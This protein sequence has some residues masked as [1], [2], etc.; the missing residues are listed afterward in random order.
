MKRIK[1]ISILVIA[2]FLVGF[3][4]VLARELGTV[5][6]TNGTSPPPIELPTTDNQQVPDRDTQSDIEVIPPPTTPLVQLGGGIV[7]Q[8]I[9]VNHGDAILVVGETGK[10]MLIDT[11]EAENRNMLKA[12]L[13]EAGV[14]RID[15]LQLTHPHSDHIGSAAW[16][17]RNYPV[18]EVHMINKEH[19]TSIYEGLLDALE[20]V[21]APVKMIE[22][23]YAFDFDGTKCEYIGPLRTNY[24]GLNNC[25]AIMRMEYGEKKLLF[26]GDLEFDGEDDLLSKYGDALDADFFKVGHHAT[27]STKEAFANAITPEVSVVS[28]KKLKYY[29]HPE[30]K[31]AILD[32]LAG[33]G[34]QV[35]MTGSHGTITVFCDGSSFKVSTSREPD[36]VDMERDFPAPS[37]IIPI[38]TE[39]LSF[40]GEKL[41]A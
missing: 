33:M 8:T 34:S 14:E 32:M 19:N 23:G 40:A 10:V 38:E 35:Y 28:S 29:T 2:L 12:A 6:T 25:S 36:D 27:N 1:I 24:R 11:G 39:P 9:D 5:G 4:F 41:A 30:R 16:V 18:G 15:I 7:V 22:P 17:L 21:S 13:E 20:E 31:Q 3:G 37:E 26:T